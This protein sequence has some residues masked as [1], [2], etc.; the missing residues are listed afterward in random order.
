MNNLIGLI[1]PVLQEVGGLHQN[2]CSPPLPRY[3]SNAC[4][5]NP[6][7]GLNVGTIGYAE[8]LVVDLTRVRN[9]QKK[10]GGWGGNIHI[11]DWV[12]VRTGFL[13][14]SD[15][16]GNKELL[17]GPIDNLGRDGVHLKDAGY[18]NLANHICVV[19]KKL[20]NSSGASFSV[21]GDRRFYWRGFSSSSGSKQRA[22]PHPKMTGNN[23]R[24]RFHTPYKKETS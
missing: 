23:R 3:L 20:G 13:P 2:S 19:I 21:S 1:M 16:P 5:N 24:G 18:T 14:D 6:E 11:L 9:L 22:K 8:G 15:R 17:P 12:G 4:C 7:H 10:G